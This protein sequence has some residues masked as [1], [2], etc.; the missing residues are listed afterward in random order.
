M[1]GRLKN[2]AF[3]ASA[4]Q[5]ARL[6][7]HRQGESDLLYR[8]GMWFLIATCDMPEPPRHASPD[9]FLGVDLGIANIATTSRTPPG[10]TRCGSTGPATAARN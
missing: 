2:L 9:A 4:D 10:A 1:A 5:L 7:A 6:S 8:D 3:T